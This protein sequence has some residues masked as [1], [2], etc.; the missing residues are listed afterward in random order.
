MI[1]EL[2][3][4]IDKAVCFHLRRYALGP[5]KGPVEKDGNF[6]CRCA[7]QDFHEI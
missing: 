4:C 7:P 3:F 2:S 1:P 5:Y 6:V